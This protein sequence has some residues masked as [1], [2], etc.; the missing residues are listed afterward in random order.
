MRQGWLRHIATGPL[1]CAIA[2]AMA[3]PLAACSVPV[4]RYA[5]ERWPADN[6]EVVIYHRGAL[7]TEQM[8]LIDKLDPETADGPKSANLAVRTIDV[9]VVSDDE[10][11]EAQRQQFLPNLD[12]D[13]NV[14]VPWLQVRYPGD[15][16]PAW[17]GSMTYGEYFFPGIV[18]MI[19]LFTAI[20]ATI[21]I[22]EDRR[23]GFLQGVLVAPIPRWSIVL[24]KVLGGTV[25]AA[26]QALIFVALAP[27]VGISLGVVKIVLLV[28]LLLLVGFG[29]TSL[30]FAIAWRMDST[31]GFHAIMNVFLM[32][33]W[34]LSG[35][36]FPAQ[37]VPG[38]LGWIIAL[39]PVTYAMAA[40]RR[41]LYLDL[42]Q[43]IP[44]GA[45]GLPRL[46]FSLGVTIAFS[47]VMFALAAAVA[48]RTRSKGST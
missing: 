6:Y 42:P 26:G 41:I 18:V 23:E 35:A 19:E 33:M 46:S 29:L 48:S 10:S 12:K 16:P 45:A 13:S 11:T 20:F 37:G 40:L 32:P 43:A 36:F 27:T 34:L 47:G 28:A 9:D 24:G 7:S 38:W 39:N 3:A 31:Q 30:G 8:S 14:G 21:S 44:T 1:A 5:L 17:A 22:I 15:L 2:L 25:L 4:F